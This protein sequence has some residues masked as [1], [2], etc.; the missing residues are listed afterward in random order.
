MSS[1]VPV[2]S[3]RHAVVTL[4]GELDIADALRPPGR[5][6]GAVVRCP[7]IVVDLAGGDFAD[8]AVLGVLVRARTW[9]AGLG[10]T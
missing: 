8:C 6:R 3:D 1:A 7:L 2:A 4:T 9:P 10:E 5:P